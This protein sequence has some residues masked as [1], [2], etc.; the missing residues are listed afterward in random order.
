MDRQVE[1]PLLKQLKLNMNKNVDKMINTFNGLPDLLKD[2]P[3]LESEN[4][5]KDPIDQA[6]KNTGPARG[7]KLHLEI[8]KRP[9][10]KQ[11][12]SFHQEI[13]KPSK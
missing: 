1:K 2:F 9:R 6:G 4:I 3:V 11:S 8:S 13:A 10:Q 12:S 5:Q 7:N